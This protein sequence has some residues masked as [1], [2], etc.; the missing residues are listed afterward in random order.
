MYQFSSLFSDVTTQ[1]HI[2]NMTFMPDTLL[3]HECHST[4]LVSW[5]ITLSG[6]GCFCIGGQLRHKS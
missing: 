1:T 6:C 2:C 3:L 4:H 5:L